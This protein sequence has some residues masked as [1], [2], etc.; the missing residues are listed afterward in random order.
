MTF[1]PV[2]GNDT[3]NGGVGIF[4]VADYR[5]DPGSVTVSLLTGMATDGWDDLDTLISI[6]VVAGSIY[7]DSI[8]GDAQDNL[9]ADWVGGNTLVGGGGFDELT[10]F[11]SGGTIT[12]DLA[13][14]TASSTNVGATDTIA[15]FEKVVIESGDTAHLIGDSANNDLIS[16]SGDDTLIGG[17]G[18][19]TLDSRAG[20]DSLDGGAGNDTLYAGEGDD[21]L[22]GGD[23]DDSLDGGAG[24]DTVDYS[25]RTYGMNIHLVNNLAQDRDLINSVTVLGVRESDTLMNIENVVGSDFV[26]VI[27]ANSVANVID[28]GSERDAVSYISAGRESGNAGFTIDWDPGT[29]DS[30]TVSNN[31]EGFE[32]DIDTLI[33][34]EGVIGSMGNDSITGNDGDNLIFLFRGSDTVD[35]GLGTDTLQYL[36]GG[37]PVEVDLALEKAD[38]GRNGTYDDTILGIEN[39]QGGGGDDL[40]IGDGNNNHL[41]GGSGNDVLE[42]AAGDDTLD[43]GDGIDTA[44]YSE[45]NG[46]GV[47]VDLSAIDPVSVTD[48]WGNTDSLISIENIIGSAFD[49]NLRG[50]S[51]D[52]VLSGGGGADAF[53]YGLNEGNDTITDFDPAQDLLSLVDGVA[54]STLSEVDVGSDGIFD[55]VVDLSTGDSIT[56]IGVTGVSD[57]DLLM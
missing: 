18:D 55:T 12:V 54:I 53:V 50:D 15:G 44:D 10:Y 32:S 21:T 14:G 24:I 8:T 25:D 19:D 37:N 23:G 3:L 1:W 29:G 41:L 7:A 39:V 45:N 49:D 40:L 33:D 52:N 4:D 2:A 42:G 31:Q 47:V 11:A 35:G 36:G 27:W 57:T 38:K 51:G 46:V 6:E 48:G 5:E 43:G 56:L 16:G 9:I 13:A 30:I 26:D 22:T 20:N 34:I 17:D 28:G